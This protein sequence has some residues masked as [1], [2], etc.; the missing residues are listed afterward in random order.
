MKGENPLSKNLKLK[1]KNGYKVILSARYVTTADGTGL[2]HCAPGHG[3]EDYEVGK[4]EG[5]D[6]IV[7]V[8]IDG[9]L[10]KEAGKYAGKRAIEV[11]K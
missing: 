7:P 9:T 1:V 3:K 4:K 10:K 2:V 11:Y 8:N 6:I 5:L